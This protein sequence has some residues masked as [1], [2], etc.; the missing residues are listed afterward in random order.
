MQ[1]GLL[2]KQGQ[3]VK[4]WKERWFVLYG[5]RLCYYEPSDW[6]QQRTSARPLGTIPL[7]DVADVKALRSRGAFLVSVTGNSAANGADRD[8]FLVA[9]SDNDRKVWIDAL[10]RALFTPNRVAQVGITRP[11]YLL[12]SQ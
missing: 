6:D 2:L 3:L 1:K 8:Y 10:H 12:V 4:S 11:P 7:A 9:A 5:D